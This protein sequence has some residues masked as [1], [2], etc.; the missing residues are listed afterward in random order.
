MKMI[1]TRMTLIAP[2]RS[3]RI[4]NIP[5]NNVM[6]DV[7]DSL[8]SASFITGILYGLICSYCLRIIA[9]VRVATNVL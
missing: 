9:S 3:L 7:V 5:P 8:N 1:M 4:K 2:G 6:I